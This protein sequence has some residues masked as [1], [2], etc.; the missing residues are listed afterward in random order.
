MTNDPP[1]PSQ[2]K[3]RKRIIP[4]EGKLWHVHEWHAECTFF[5]GLPV[6]LLPIYYYTT[7]IT[8]NGYIH[9]LDRLTNTISSQFSSPIPN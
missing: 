8:Y 3:M 1:G 5:R 9:L 7:T 6:S 2:E 4:E